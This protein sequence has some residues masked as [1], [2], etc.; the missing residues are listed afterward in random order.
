MTTPNGP[1]GFNNVNQEMGLT[2]R[3][4]SATYRYVN[5]LERHNPPEVAWS[6]LVNRS[7]TW[8]INEPTDPPYRTSV[9]QESNRWNIL[10]FFPNALP[11][12]SFNVVAQFTTN[13]AGTF[14]L[15]NNQ[16]FYGYLMNNIRIIPGIRGVT[17]KT[18]VVYENN[19][20]Y[21]IIGIENPAKRSTFFMRG[22]VQSVQY[23]PAIPNP[24][25]LP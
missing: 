21:T 13:W 23:L 7:R 14:I 25:V 24:P 16:F 11:G 18:H 15:D 9:T 4:I 1:I 6:R 10:D 19:Q 8:E 12:D 5:L 3:P 2:P 20:I 17:F 22:G